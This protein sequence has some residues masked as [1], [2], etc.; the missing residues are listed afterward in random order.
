MSFESI[1]DDLFSA[2]D[3]ALVA[4]FE[5]EGA[6]DSTKVRHHRLRDR[7]T[8]PD[9]L[10]CLRV[11]FEQES[12]YVYYECG[13]R[14]PGTGSPSP[15]AID[16]IVAGTAQLG[17]T[18]VTDAGYVLDARWFESRIAEN[19]ID[20]DTAADDVYRFGTVLMQLALAPVYQRLRRETLPELPIALSS[21]F[22][23]TVFD[24]VHT[25]EDE[26]RPPFFFSGEALTLEIEDI[27]GVLDRL[28]DT[29]ESKA[30]LRA[31]FHEQEHRRPTKR[32][33]AAAIADA[34]ANGA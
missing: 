26:V 8:A 6:S 5:P 28:C 3:K 13:E 2:F 19:D 24:D 4:L 18:I 23:F 12:L 1:V 9:T 10:T 32:R 33:T 30:Y 25:Y 15:M 7:W 21:A 29:E 27:L 14:A 22:A 17:H 11:G 34:V 31:V 16:D 20:P